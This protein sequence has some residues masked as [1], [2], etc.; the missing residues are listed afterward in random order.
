MLKKKPNSII[1]NILQK[2]SESEHFEE[3]TGFFDREHHG[4][5]DGIK[6][7]K[8]VGSYFGRKTRTILKSPLNIF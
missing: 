7:R 4:N 5:F 2:L 8:V 6:G 3:I 1:M